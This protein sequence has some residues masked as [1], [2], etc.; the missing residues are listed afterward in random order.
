MKSQD[1]SRIRRNECATLDRRE[2]MESVRTIAV[3]IGS[4]VLMDDLGR[5]EPEMFAHIARQVSTLMAEGY[6]MVIITSG[7]IL[8]GRAKIKLTMDRDSIPVKQA[9]AAIGQSDIMRFYEQ[10]FAH[11]G[12]IVAQVLLTRDDL[13]NRRRYLNARHTLMCLM[14]MKVIPI[15]NENDTVMVEEI[16]FGDNDNLAAMVTPLVDADLL[17]ILS[18]VSGLFDGDP[19]LG[20]ATC[21]IPVVDRV[22]ERIE[23][24][25]GGARPG[26]GLGGM[27]TKVNAAK[28]AARYGVPT[29]VAHGKE[30]D[31]ILR[32]IRGEDIGTIFLPQE[33]RLTSR[34]HWIAYTL[35]SRGDLVLDSGAVDALVKGGKSLLA[36]GI[37]EVR[38]TFAKGELVVCLCEDGKPIARGLVNYSSSEIDKIKGLHSSRIQE[39]LEF[40]VTD[41]VIHRDNMVLL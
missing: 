26:L 20:K 5:L 22:D 40:K 9:M 18:D 38:G 17:I 13:E 6:R 4:S 36:S 19:S 23:Q 37:V 29:V 7:A 14:E 30:R 27:I 35:K 28:R 24:L 34:K 32:I 1:V 15:I 41:E 11:Y 33:D 10:F 8:A 16:H 2:C 21:V 3:K 25:A 12:F 39:V 31:I